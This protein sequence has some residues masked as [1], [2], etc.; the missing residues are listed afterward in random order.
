MDE[1]ICVMS[2]N[3]R[4]LVNILDDELR[5]MVNLIHPSAKFRCFF[6]SCHSGSVLDLPYGW[7][8]NRTFTTESKALNKNILMVSGCMDK[9]FSHETLVDKNGTSACHGALTYFMIETFKEF[10][11][12]KPLRWIDLI[13][14]V[15]EKIKINGYKQI[16][17]SGFCNISTLLSTFDL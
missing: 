15:Q 14:F 17:Q 10:K 6:D 5:V 4:T 16:P 1:T 7:Y 9:Q 2:D 12:K 11:N 8:I 13:A 3:R